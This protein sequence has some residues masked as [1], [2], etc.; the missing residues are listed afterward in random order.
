MPRHFH[1]NY[2]CVIGMPCSCHGLH[3]IN[4]LSTMYVEFMNDLKAYFNVSVED[5][6]PVIV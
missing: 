4:D 6:C 3:D 1:E 2:E 5:S